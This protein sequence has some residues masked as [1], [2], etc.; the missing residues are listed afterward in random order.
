MC[1]RT[2]RRT[3]GAGRLFIRVPPQ[4]DAQ[5][6]ALFQP[7]LYL[8]EVQGARRGFGHPIQAPSEAGEF[9]LGKLPEGRRLSY[10]SVYY[11]RSCQDV[12]RQ[13][14]GGDRKGGAARLDACL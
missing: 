11:R 10:P 3:E 6:E 5:S 13:R 1:A 2:V 14:A 8:L 7:S 4:H 12:L 9:D